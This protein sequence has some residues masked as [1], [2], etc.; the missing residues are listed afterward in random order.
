MAVQTSPMERLSTRARYVAQ[1]SARVGWYAGQAFRMRRM[2]QAAIEKDPSLKPDVQ[3]PK[4]NVP[5]VADLLR[6]VAALSVRDL[7]NIEAGMYPAPQG[8]TDWAKRIEEARE[9]FKEVPLVARRRADKRHQEARQAPMAEKRPRYYQQN[10]HFQTDGWMSERSARLYDTQVE[11]LFS[12]ATEAMRR[13]VLVPIANFMKDRDQ[14]QMVAVDL[15]TGPGNMADALSHTYP[16]M[17]ILALDL[18]EPYTKHALG[19]F[20]KAKHHQG[21]VG[22]AEQLPFADNSI[23][24]L[25]CVFLFHELPPKI[26]VA[27]CNEIARVL[28]PGGMFAFVDSLQP[29]DAPEYDG[30]LELFPQLFHEPYYNSYAQTDLT[31][32]FGRPGLKCVHTNTAFVSK[33]LAFEKTH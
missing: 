32:L 23:D 31:E 9:F 8:A 11:V 6:G 3:P 21:T 5:G 27:V 24:L 2:Q 18:S 15:A 13:Q 33:I 30:L 14:R 22:K 16:R 10:F 4:G 28:K 20:R 25:T 17:P 1:Q 29:G 12:G 26:R 7:A 19:R